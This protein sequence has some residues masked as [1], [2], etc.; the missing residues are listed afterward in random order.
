MKKLIL[1]GGVLVLLVGGWWL[2]NREQTATD[3]EEVSTESTEESV[4]GTIAEIMARGIAVKCSY[5]VN[6]VEYEGYIK[7]DQY[8]GQMATG[9]Q[10]QEVIIANG[11]LYTW[12]T[13]GDQ[14]VKMAYELANPD[15]EDYLDMDAVYNCS[16]S[17]VEDDLFVPPEDVSFID[18]SQ[19]SSQNT[20]EDSIEEQ[21][22]ELA[23]FY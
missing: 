19:A 5:D 8:R 12:Q 18:W 6:G 23:E 14:G 4:T 7:G 13:G 3:Q 21:L 1:I 22:E 10:T 9:D 16:P 20:S 17:L 15:E 11:Y 2:F